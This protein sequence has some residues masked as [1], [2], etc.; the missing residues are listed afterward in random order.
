MENG[1]G[2]HKILIIDDDRTALDGY[3]Q[4]LEGQ[5]FS[6]A[7]CSD[8]TQAIPML[9]A[10]TYNVAVLDIRMPGIE[11]TDLL[12]LIK[13]I[14]PDLPVILASA[15]C[16]EKDA[17]YYHSL[18]ASEI[19]T[20]PFSPEALLD[21]LARAMDQQEKIPLVLTNLSLRECRDQVYRKL[22]LTALRKTNWN[23]VKSAQLLG[24]SRYCL[25]RWLKK[26]SIS[27]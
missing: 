17:G 7:T 21:T 3:K 4:A 22:I 18:G 1:K 8:S 15:Y 6:V 5:G 10:N 12:P 2:P 20:K 19:L 25:I 26:L 24:I 11:G 16:D 27:Y 9:K 13:K 23:Q 14:R